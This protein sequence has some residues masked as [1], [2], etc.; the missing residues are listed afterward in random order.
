M[1]FA[2]FMIPGVLCLI[3]GVFRGLKANAAGKTEVKNL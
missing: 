3:W 1:P 2:Y